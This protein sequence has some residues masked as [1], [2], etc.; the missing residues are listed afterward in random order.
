MRRL[1][2][3]IAVVVIANVVAL[4]VVPRE[5]FYNALSVE[6][7]CLPP[8]DL[9]AVVIL[10]RAWQRDPGL[11]A[12]KD[13]LALAVII[14]GISSLLAILGLSRLGHFALP[15]DTAGLGI[16]AFAIGLSMVNLVFVVR[17]WDAAWK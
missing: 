9:L 6:V 5:T 12:I 1:L 2:V 17:Y 14:T 11:G 8:I 15:N 16:V 7:I 4:L 3:F 13:R 10:L